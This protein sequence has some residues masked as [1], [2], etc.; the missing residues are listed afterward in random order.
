M[1]LTRIPIQGSALNLPA[2]A[3][4]AL[5]HIAKMLIDARPPARWVRNADLA[6]HC[7]SDKQATLSQLLYQ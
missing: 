3:I 7:L 4:N 6:C 1:Q 5:A 2:L